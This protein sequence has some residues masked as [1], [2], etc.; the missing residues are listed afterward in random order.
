METR[1]RKSAPLP[2][3]LTAATHKFL[4]LAR[5]QDK[6]FFHHVNCA[7]PRTKDRS[8]IWNAWSDGRTQYR[9]ENMNG[10]T[11]KA[12]LA[13][14][15]SDP[16]I[17]AR[18][19]FYLHRVPEEF[20]DLTGDRCERQNL[21]QD[22]S[23][24]AEIA[25]LR[26]ELLALMQRTGDPLA[27]AFAQR[28]KPEVL[29]A[30]RQKLM[31]EYQ[32]PPRAKAKAKAKRAA[33]K[34]AS[35]PP[36]LAAGKDLIAFVLPQAVVATEPVTVGIRHQF[37]EDAG[38]QLIRINPPTATSQTDPAHKKRLP[39]N[40]SPQEPKAPLAH[41]RLGYPSSGCSPALPDSVSPSNFHPNPTPNPIQCRHLPD[42]LLPTG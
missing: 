11:W 2:D 40:H 28:D 25:S 19:D 32:R 21:I 17:Q 36:E 26:Q 9:A 14:A 16:T 8:Y 3:Q 29:A 23:R 7:D 1:R 6:P 38:Q 30:A 5:Q 13:A 24:Q 27:E 10:L 42:C 22:P 35:M 4:T 15:D 18:T 31:D 37:P 20:Y 12:M 41:P 39:E 34:A 33:A